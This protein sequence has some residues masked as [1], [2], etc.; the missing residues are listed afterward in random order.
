[1]RGGQVSIFGL[2]EETV[3][4]VDRMDILFRP[5]MESVATQGAYRVLSSHDPDI[6]GVVVVLPHLLNGHPPEHFPLIFRL[7]PISK[8]PLLM[9]VHCLVRSGL[10]YIYSLVDLLIFEI[11]L[12]HSFR[13]HL[14]NLDENK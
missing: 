11:K 10:N 4:P 3:I 2:P 13:G 12:N 6:H 7:C 5:N 8:S 14:T 1:M 9:K